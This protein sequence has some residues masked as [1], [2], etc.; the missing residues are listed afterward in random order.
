MK[1]ASLIQGNYSGNYPENMQVTS[2]RSSSRIGTGESEQHFHLWGIFIWSGLVILL[3]TLVV[4]RFRTPNLVWQDLNVAD[5]HVSISGNHGIFASEK[6]GLNDVFITEVIELENW[7]VNLEGWVAD[8]PLVKDAIFDEEPFMALQPWMTQPGTWLN[9]AY[10]DEFIAIEPW[11]VEMDAWSATSVVNEPLLEVEDWMTDIS[12]WESS[13]GVAMGESDF[14]AEEMV[15]LEPWM[16]DP[17]SWV[18]DEI[19]SGNVAATAGFD[20]FDIEVKGWML[21]LDGW[22]AP[23][24][25]KAPSSQIKDAG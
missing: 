4:L 21:N 23:L 17:D 1:R 11:M 3:L 24:K 12:S 13:Y 14:I 25:T 20:E 8:A 5:N 6:M 10:F 18:S 22:F 19:H 7:M 15:T 9:P 16:T 2:G